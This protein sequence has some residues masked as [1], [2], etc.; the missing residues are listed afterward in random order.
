MK[1]QIR[2]IALDM[3]GTLLDDR[4]EISPAT[5]QVLTDLRGKGRCYVMHEKQQPCFHITSRR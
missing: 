3:D 5:C 1:R 4:K 2:L